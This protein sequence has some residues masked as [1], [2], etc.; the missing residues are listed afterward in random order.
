MQAYGWM[1]A[2]LWTAPL[3][4]GIFATI[5]HA[6]PFWADLHTLLG[7]EKS[8]DPD[9]ARAL[10]AFLLATIFSGR[11]LKNFLPGLIEER[12]KGANLLQ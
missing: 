4:T 12:K 8:V 6:Q 1:T 3:M 10:V 7:A 2:D 9:S 5:T 11:T